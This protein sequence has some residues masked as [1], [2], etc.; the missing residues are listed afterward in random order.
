MGPAEE[1]GREGLVLGWRVGGSAGPLKVPGGKVVDLDMSVAKILG[2][3]NMEATRGAR[4]G[5]WNWTEAGTSASISVQV[6]LGVGGL[7]P[8]CVPGAGGSLSFS[9]GTQGRWPG[10][11]CALICVAAARSLALLCNTLTSS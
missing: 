10:E 5:N 3:A 9:T 7:R 11:G 2:C 1:L 8:P 4:R 6:R